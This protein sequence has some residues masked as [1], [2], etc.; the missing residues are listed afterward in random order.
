MRKSDAHTSEH[1]K[2]TYADKWTK[3]QLSTLLKPQDD[4]KVRENYE[5]TVALKILS[6][7]LNTSEKV[8]YS[9]R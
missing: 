5:R 7:D 8:R 6:L 2:N 1:W 3:S 9:G 4:I